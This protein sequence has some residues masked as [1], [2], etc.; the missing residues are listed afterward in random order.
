MAVVFL[1]KKTGIVIPH[2]NSKYKIQNVLPSHFDNSKLICF[3]QET[4]KSRSP[5]GLIEGSSCFERCPEA[6][7]SS[8]SLIASAQVISKNGIRLSE[9]RV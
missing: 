6:K 8:T 5:K 7:R 3:M 1:V 2:Q 9:S 4:I